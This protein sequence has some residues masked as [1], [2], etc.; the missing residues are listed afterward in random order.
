MLVVGMEDN[1]PYPSR[2]RV[3]AQF[4]LHGATYRLGVTDPPV[5]REYLAKSDGQYPIPTALICVSLGEVFNGYAYKLAA[6]II[7]PVRAGGRP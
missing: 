2:R 5:E 7:M 3:R 6:A 4:N 1:S